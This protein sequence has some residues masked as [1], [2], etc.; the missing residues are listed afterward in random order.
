MLLEHSQVEN[1]ESAVWLKSQQN[2]EN[3]KSLYLIISVENPFKSLCETLAD[4]GSYLRTS[5]QIP[6]LWLCI[7]AL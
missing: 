3:L 5:V 2:K 6:E 1:N 7:S 4:T